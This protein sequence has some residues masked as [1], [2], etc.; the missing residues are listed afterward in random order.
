MWYVIQEYETYNDKKPNHF[1]RVHH[2]Y[3]N[4][5]DAEKAALKLNFDE[6]CKGKPA[7]YPHIAVQEHYDT[8]TVYKII[9]HV[10]TNINS[11]TGSKNRYFGTGYWIINSDRITI[12]PDTVDIP[13][14][15]ELLTAEELKAREPEESE[16]DE[17]SSSSETE[18]EKDEKPSTEP[19][20]KQEGLVSD[21]SDLE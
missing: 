2:E 4:K 20:E 11:K 19:E 14:I 16:S 7:R 17:S 21:E 3:K 1:W 18:S 8:K 15:R 5:Q 10:L 13:N 9:E 12:K 6:F